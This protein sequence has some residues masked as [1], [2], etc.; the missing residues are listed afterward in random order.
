MA[1]PPLYTTRP[2]LARSA[3]G[4]TALR[5]TRTRRDWEPETYRREGRTRP[6]TEHVFAGR[7]QYPVRA[8]V[9]SESRES[10]EEHAEESVRG[11][12]SPVSAVVPAV[13]RARDRAVPPA[14]GE[15]PH[16]AARDLAAGRQ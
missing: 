9:A 5:W 16:R 2:F 11:R 15:G 1:A 10:E 13:R 7:V 4:R 12:A 3:D 14:V 6:S 8:A